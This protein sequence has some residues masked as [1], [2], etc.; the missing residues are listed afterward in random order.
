VYHTIHQLR[1]INRIYTEHTRVNVFRTRLLY[2][3]SSTTAITAV[4]LT[5]PTYAWLFI[6]KSLRDRIAVGITVPITAL[7]LVAFIWPQLGARRLMA[8]EKR[9]MLDD[10]SLRFEALIVE[11]PQRV[12]SRDFEGIDNLK[13]LIAALEIEEQALKKVSTLPWRPETVRYLMTALLL[14]LVLWLVQYFLQSA[15]GP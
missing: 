14:P 8:Q 6:N 11:L 13:K 5:I 2:A 7:A 10:L 12:D 3:F 1:V 4:S 9:R 15:L